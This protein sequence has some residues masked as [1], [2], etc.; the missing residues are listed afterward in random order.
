MGIETAFTFAHP[1]A[2]AGP[3]RL[4]ADISATGPSAAGATL[5]REP[6]PFPHL[7]LVERRGLLAGFLGDAPQGSGKKS[8]TGT[9]FNMIWRPNHG[10]QSGPKDF[11]LEMN[12]TKETL[13]FTDITGHNGVANRG[14]LQDD[15]FLGAIAYLQQINDS[16]DGT[17]QHFEPGVWVNVPKTSAPGE[18]SSVSRMGSIPHGTTVNLE[19]VSFSAPAPAITASSITP[20]TVGS[21]DDGVTGL[22]HFDEEDLTKPS[23]SR[24]PTTRVPGLTP[25]HLHNPNLFLTDA[26]K[27]LTFTSTAVIIIASNPALMPPSAPPVPPHADAGGGLANI[28]YLSGKP[29]QDTNVTDVTAIFWIEKAKRANGQE[30]VQLQYTQRVLLTFNGL[31]WPHVTVATL[32]PAP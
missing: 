5:L 15:I 22:V 18:P 12:M 21:P 10:G 20:F 28:A 30:V 4:E 14:L 27:G 9:G 32:H 3:E 26:N 2:G 11:F 25:D 19:G 16:F 29:A 8:W 13:D 17:G 23:S 24:T 1:L 31:K 7:P 6:F